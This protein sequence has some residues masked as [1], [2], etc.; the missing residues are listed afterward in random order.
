[1]FIQISYGNAAISMY[2]CIDCDQLPKRRNLRSLIDISL[3]LIF[4]A[5][6]FK[7]KCIIRTVHCTCM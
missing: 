4:S 5:I 7:M 6:T 1:M 2:D 3:Y